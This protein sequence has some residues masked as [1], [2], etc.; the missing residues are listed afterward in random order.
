MLAHAM[1][2]TF[3]TRV[4]SHERLMELD[5]RELTSLVEQ[6][7]DDALG[8]I[9][10]SRWATLP[11]VMMQAE[12]LR[13][14]GIALDW[15]E[16]IERPRSPF[17]VARIEASTTVELGGLTFRLKLDRIDTLS[18]GTAAIIDYKTGLV[19]ST[20]AWFAWRPRAPQLGVYMLALGLEPEPVP[21]RAI[22]YGRLKA[23]EIQVI[24]FAADV[25]QWRALQD[26]SKPR[27]PAGW[28]G[29]E[30]FFQERI[31]A[32]A[33]E[34]RDGIAT[35][36][37]RPPP[38]SPCRICGRQSL[39]RIDAVRRGAPDEERNGER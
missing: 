3:W 23:D 11:A 14:P 13:L 6:A 29:I 16:A 2:A 30:R 38:N 27:D 28:S 19:D 35:V 5:E 1:M 17:T 18:D 31:P 8:T 22:A 24:G 33:A 21:V 10:A 20:Q 25:T 7:A 37:P 32:I 34:I 36:T 12:R 4:H 39:C 26:A 15:I 9:P